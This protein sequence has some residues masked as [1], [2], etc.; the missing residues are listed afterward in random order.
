MESVKILREYFV[1]EDGIIKPRDKRNSKKVYSE[2]ELFRWLGDFA[3]N[4]NLD[5]NKTFREQSIKEWKETK[6][7]D[8]IIV[9]SKENIRNFI[10]KV[11]E[12]NN[13]VLLANQQY[14][15]DGTQYS[16][17]DVELK[18]EHEIFD[19]NR[20]NKANTIFDKELK[21]GLLDMK[22]DVFFNK[23]KEIIEKISYNEDNKNDLEDFLKLTHKVFDI[24]ES[25][26]VFSTIMKHFMWMVK[27]RISIKSTINQIFI[28]FCGKGATGKTFYVKLFTEPFNLFRINNA[29]IETVQDERRIKELAD[30]FIHFIDELSGEKRM[31]TDQD[32]GIFKQV[33]TADGPLTYRV[34]GSHVSQSVTP[35]TSMIGCSN[36]HIFDTINDSSGMRRFFEFNI[37][38]D[39]H[40]YNEEDFKLLETM[41]VEAWKGIDENLDSGYYKLH[42]EVGQE[43][44]KIQASYCRKES[45][46]LWLDSVTIK[47][48]KIKGT[49]VYDLYKN[50]C[51]TEGLEYK[52]KQIQTF[53]SRLESLGYKKFLSNGYTYIKA[54]F[55]KK[56][57]N[58][59]LETIGIKSNKK[60]EGIE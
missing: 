31:Y 58:E 5:W 56:E 12:E 4:K 27:R 57:D 14:L 28:N 11:F 7:D 49:E 6:I 36:F 60:L 21:T 16:E 44:Q 54:E 33:I 52:Q 30:N 13:I 23:K 25:Y 38:I 45:F 9:D 39:S 1:Y 22:R 17:Q 43:I 32:L 35:T 41:C 40:K 59:F 29:K 48:G 34:L 51:E 47:D 10:L 42:D 53:Y 18:L 46:E 8:P 37:R 20:K 24:A 3:D 55:I 15:R 2:N 50:F 19:W 26:E